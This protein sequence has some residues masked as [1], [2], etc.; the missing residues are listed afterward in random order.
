VEVQCLAA[1]SKSGFSAIRRGIRPPRLINR[2]AWPLHVQRFERIF[3]FRPQ[4]EA[5]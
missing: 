3:R 1:A 5:Q 4:A 2:A